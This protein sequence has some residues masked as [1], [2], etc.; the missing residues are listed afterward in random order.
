MGAYTE[1]IKWNV[2]V[3]GFPFFFIFF[4]FFICKYLLLTYNITII[5]KYK[6]L[7]I[8][9]GATLQ[10]SYLTKLILLT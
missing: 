1:N 2:P 3:F 6:S 8:T 5:T 7:N 10:Y 4:Y 9:Q